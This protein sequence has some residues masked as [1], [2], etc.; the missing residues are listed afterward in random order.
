MRIVLLGPPGAGKGSL[1]SIY[2]ERLGIAHLST[3]EIFRREIERKSRL[4]KRVSRYVG[5]G[6]LVPDALV[7][8]VEANWKLDLPEAA[9]DALRVLA[10]NYP[11]YPAFDGEGNL[12]L[13]ETIR[14]R[15]RTWLNIMTL[16]VFARPEV[17]PPL[18][19]QHPEGFVPPEPPLPRTVEQEKKKKGW[20]SWL[21]F[22]G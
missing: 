3:G 1:A 22:I 16:G 20:F 11:N 2:K 14:N 12:V 6:R 18:K 21:P 8:M 5:A 9:N 15:D 4:G 17:P 7:V 10:I 13:D 19:I